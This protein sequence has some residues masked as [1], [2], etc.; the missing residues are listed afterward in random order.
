MAIGEYAIF[1]SDDINEMNKLGKGE[2]SGKN[3]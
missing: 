2:L 3:H 1:L